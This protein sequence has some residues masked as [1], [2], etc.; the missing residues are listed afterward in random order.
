MNSSLKTAAIALMATAAL[1][2]AARTASDF[3]AQAP[4][5]VM[6][7]LSQVDRLDMA[8]YYAYGSAAGVNDVFDSPWHITA[9]SPAAITIAGGD[10]S[11]IQL[12]VIPAGR[13]T[14]VAV[15]TTVALPARDSRVQFYKA[16]WSPAK[17][18]AMP[19]YTDW[20]LPGADD[21]SDLETTLPFVTAEAAFDS[22]ATTLTFTNTAGSYLSAPDYERL[23]PVLVPSITLDIANGRFKTRT[24]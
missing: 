4:A 2:T 22:T 3:L 17:A 24:R 18:P 14:L 23:R 7:L 15:V 6:P 10:S 21:I 5:S 9:M 16:D 13:D 8:D 19:R 12:A 20:L 1:G 11:T